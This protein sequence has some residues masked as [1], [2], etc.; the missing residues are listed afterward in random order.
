LEYA[1]TRGRSRAESIGV[2]ADSDFELEVRERLSERGYQ[3]D[4]QIG[5][6]GFR[7]DLGIR[8][9]DHPERFLAGIECDGAQ[10]HS[11][12]SARDRD[13]LREQVLV[14]LGWEI[15]RVWSTDWF[16]DPTAETAKLTKRL[17]ALRARPPTARDD[18]E[19]V[20]PEVTLG[21]PVVAAYQP[22]EPLWPSDQPIGQSHEPDHSSKTEPTEGSEDR[23]S[24][25]DISQALEEFRDTV[26]AKEIPDWDRHRSVLRDAMIET[27]VKQRFVDPDEWF[28][29]I[30]QFMRMATNPLEKRL[31]LGRIC[32]IV[33][34][35]DG[36]P[37]PAGQQAPVEVTGASDTTSALI[38]APESNTNTMTPLEPA[39]QS[40][41]EYHVVDP[42]KC[43]EA[44]SADHFYDDSYRRTL[45]VL[46]ER[47]VST[48]G[49]VYFDVLVNR[50]A[51]A[52]GFQRS[53]NTIQT[54]IMSVVD[55]RFPRSNEED[56][57][58]LWPVGANPLSIVTY[59]ASTSRS[60][61][62]VPLYE[63]AGLAKAYLK[64]RMTDGD[65]L[66]RMGDHFQL[67]RV[68]EAARLRFEAAI[69][70]ANGES[71]MQ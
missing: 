27:F 36:R 70:L 10:Y 54:T 9:P 44:L 63:L 11:S 64:L 16:A 49:P 4:L 20:H 29:L 13:R 50:I 41:S 21:Q 8:H 6:S 45:S 58:V 34:R 30:P 32:E 1:E 19:I 2:D 31:Y 14:G 62:D 61:A 56:R 67:D 35:L 7:I 57:L 68:R 26:I 53:G 60:Y 12:P 38:A 48:E 25:K 66:R 71:A 69:A 65:V 42:S 47:I 28:N 43:G 59:R 3:V 18:Y 40:A 55:R 24:E 46:V 15:I 52:H 51:R 17:E 22:T 37:A 23:P 39:D 5:V 33:G